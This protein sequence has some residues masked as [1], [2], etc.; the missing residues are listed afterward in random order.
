[1]LE[2]ATTLEQGSEHPLAKAVIPPGSILA[3]WREAAADP[4]RQAEL[5]TLA[6]HVQTLL[7]KR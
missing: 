5:E 2:I 1:M 4:K 3:Q 6:R 7:R